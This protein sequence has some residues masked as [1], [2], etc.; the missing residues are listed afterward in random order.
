MTTPETG[1]SSPDPSR[2]TPDEIGTTVAALTAAS[3]LAGWV[4]FALY[5]APGELPALP[6]GEADVGGARVLWAGLALDEAGRTEVARM[7]TGARAA[8]TKVGILT[9]GRRFRPHLTVARLGRPWPVGPERSPP[10][11][12]ASSPPTGSWSGAA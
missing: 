1:S 11:S 3:G 7:A 10:P 12:W 2:T 9:E 5:G 6:P 4:E 8:A